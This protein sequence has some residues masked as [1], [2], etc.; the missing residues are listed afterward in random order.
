M[1]YFDIC[2][3]IDTNQSKLFQYLV[4][5]LRS[6]DDKLIDNIP[7]CE[8]QHSLKRGIVNKIH[9]QW[10]SSLCFR[11]ES[12]LPLF[13]KCIFWPAECLL[14][15]IALKNIKNRLSG[16]ISMTEFEESALRQ[17]IIQKYYDIYISIK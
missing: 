10:I 1:Q 17:E 5:N 6:H 16:E 3:S 12:Y 14:D 15:Y 2:F 9:D 4:T 7:M 8:L 13:F 11:H